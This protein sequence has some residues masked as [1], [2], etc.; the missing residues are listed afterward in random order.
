MSITDVSC[1]NR[2]LEYA[3]Y[4]HQFYNSDFP[5]YSSLDVDY[6]HTTQPVF[7]GMRERIGHPPGTNR[8]F[9]PFSIYDDTPPRFYQFTA[10]NHRAFLYAP[11]TGTYKVTV[12]DWDDITLIWLGDKA[13]S[14]WTR[15]NAD[16][17]Q[18]FNT[19]TS[20]TETTVFNIE[21]VAGTYMP[22]LLLWANAQGELSFTAQIT[23]PDGRVIVDGDGSDSDFLVR[24]ACDMS[25]PEF[26]PL[27]ATG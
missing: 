20:P 10:V 25:T 9:P 19:V 2:G 27:G 21:L 23:A 14:S 5:T 18:D 7:T 15:A 13:I 1:N 11:V 3:I 26:P 17:E 4:E 16:L 24:F 6:F 12:P 8:F 22:F